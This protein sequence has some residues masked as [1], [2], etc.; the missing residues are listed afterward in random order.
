METPETDVIAYEG[1]SP[2]IVISQLK[3]LVQSV[4]SI[5][6][7]NESYIFQKLDNSRQKF[8]RAQREWEEAQTETSRR[9]NLVQSRRENEIH[10]I[11]M[12]ILRYR[13]L[14]QHGR[15]IWMQAYELAKKYED[16]PTEL[17]PEGDIEEGEPVEVQIARDLL[18]NKLGLWF[19]ADMDE[20]KRIL[21]GW[22]LGNLS[23]PTLNEGP[24]KE[25]T[26]SDKN[27]PLNMV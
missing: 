2:A 20:W 18:D 14:E 9:L 15:K 19:S 6:V 27:S 21:F 10:R 22:D 12:K 13:I 4:K 11:Q 3:N 25:E 17:T 16:N 5:A 8:E 26:D 23:E 7:S 24:L 1:T